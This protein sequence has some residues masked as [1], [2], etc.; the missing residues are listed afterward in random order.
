V[1]LVLARH[2]RSTANVARILDSAPPGAPLDELG[3]EQAAQLGARL[4]DRPVRA[5]HAS[6]ALRARQTAAPVATAHG[7]P[8]DVV[9]GVH[10]V[11][12]GDLEGRSDPAALAAFDEVYAAW[13]RGDLA[14]RP[15]GG[16]SA[17]DLRARYLPAVERIVGGAAADGDVV[18]VSHGAAIRLVAAALLGDTA[19][20]WYVPNAGVVVLRPGRAGW[21][22]ESWDTAPPVA[23]DVTAGGAP[24]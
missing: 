21:V 15:P 23:G 17:L 16:E 18:L 3:R 19:E 8:V 6:R 12:L 1:R 13:W 9:D 10:E 22:L 11:F 7:L 14:A 24:D 5:V 4:A 2:G 20:T